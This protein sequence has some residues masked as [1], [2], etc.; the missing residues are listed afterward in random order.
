ML[1]FINPEQFEQLKAK[2]Y[3]SLKEYITMLSTAPGSL[4][5]GLSGE[6]LASE[7]IKGAIFLKK[8]IETGAAPSLSSDQ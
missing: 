5:T 3:D 2:N 6:E 4:K 7:I 1:E 8:F